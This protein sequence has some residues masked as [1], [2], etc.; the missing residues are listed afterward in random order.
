[1]HNHPNA[2]ITEF[3]FGK[4]F[5]EAWN[6]GATVGNAVKGFQYTGM[7]PLKPSAILDD[8]S[9]PSQYFKQDST[10]N[11]LSPDTL[12]KS[13]VSSPKTPK[14]SGQSILQS[15]SY[16]SVAELSRTTQQR[17]ETVKKNAL[18][19]IIPTLEKKQS[20]KKRLKW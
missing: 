4:L 16:L 12:D 11:S 6:K 20:W 2:A 13:P 14:P 7:F 8:K 5:S 3:H 19:I 1:M 17:T 15:T 18:S 9:L 10:T